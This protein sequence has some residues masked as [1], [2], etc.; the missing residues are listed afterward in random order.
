MPLP[1]VLWSWKWRWV[2][3]V[4]T[5]DETRETEDTM[6]NCVQC[7]ACLS[8]AW[9]HRAL[10]LLRLSSN[11]PHRRILYHY[12]PVLCIFF[13]FLY[14]L[15]HWGPKC[16]LW[17]MCRGQRN[18]CRSWLSPSTMWDLGIKVRS[19]GL[20]ASTVHY[21]LR[22]LFSPTLSTFSRLPSPLHHESL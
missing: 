12:G 11:P 16:M 4:G 20:A 21:P 14:V 19:S 7:R 5:E 3:W 9:I 15:I 8:V 17:Y 10:G 6:E 2:V 22:H 13:N 1:Y 18:T